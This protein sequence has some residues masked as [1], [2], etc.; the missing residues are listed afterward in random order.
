MSDLR[1]QISSAF[2]TDVSNYAPTQVTHGITPKRANLSQIKKVCKEI[3]FSPHIF[4]PSLLSFSLDAF[5]ATLSG[6]P[7]FPICKREKESG[8]TAF[9]RLKLSSVNK[10]CL[11]ELSRQLNSQKG[12]NSINNT[13]GPEDKAHSWGCNVGTSWG[14]YKMQLWS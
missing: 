1:M 2:R 14:S 12:P 3:N 9:P 13:T 10:A 4:L 6:N 5:V 7:S 11:H 8:K